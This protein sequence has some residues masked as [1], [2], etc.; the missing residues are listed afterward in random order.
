MIQ[1]ILSSMTQTLFKRDA[2]TT[3]ALNQLEELTAGNIKVQGGSY[4][5]V[6]LI[7]LGVSLT[8]VVNYVI[9][10]IIFIYYF[11]I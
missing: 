11:H 1:F 3:G 9:Q 7:L 5:S 4:T 10:C 2:N 6:F 8:H